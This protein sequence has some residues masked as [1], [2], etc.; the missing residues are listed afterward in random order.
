MCNKVIDKSYQSCSSLQNRQ[1]FGLGLSLSVS[2]AD[3]ARFGPSLPAYRSRRRRNLVNG[4]RL[5]F[6]L[7]K[8]LK[9]AVQHNVNPF[10]TSPGDLRNLGRPFRYEARRSP[11]LI[12]WDNYD[13]IK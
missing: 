4:V 12:A 1:K 7:G 2:I 3:L 9:G 6:I 13:V 5:Q 11:G 10:V 8:K